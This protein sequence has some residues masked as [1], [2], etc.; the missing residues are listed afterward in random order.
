MGPLRQ[1]IAALL[2]VGGLAAATATAA[3]VRVAIE[4]D[5]APLS[6]LSPEGKPTGFAVDLVHAIA[7]EMRFEVAPVVGPWDKILTAFKQGEADVLASVAYLPERAEFIDFAV[8]HLTFKAAI[9][10]RDDSPPLGGVADIAKVRVAVARE[11][12]AYEYLRSRGLDR[13]PVF[14]NTLQ[15]ALEA[16]DAGR[17][18]AVLGTAV[19]SAH[20]IRTRNFHRVVPA[21]LVL[22]DLAYQLHLGVRSG[23]VR[24]LA[25]LN[26]GL[27][28]IRAN[29]VYDRIYEEWIGPLEPR[30]LRFKDVHPYLLPFAVLVAAVAGAF[31]WQRRL[32]VRLA[33]QTDQIRASEERL[34][35]VL[36]GSSDGFWDWDMVT[37]RIERSERWA[38]MLGYT[39]AEITPTHAGG[40]SHIHADDLPNYRIWE[41][42]LTTGKSDRYEVEYRMR[43]KSGD[44][45]WVL[46]RGKVVSRDANG[47]PLRMAGTHTDITKRKQTEAALVESQRLLHRSHELLEQTQ[48]VARIGGWEIDLRTRHLYWTEGNYQIHETTAADYQPTVAGALEF[49]S[50]ESRARLQ[51]ALEQ[52]GAAGAALDLELDLVTARGRRRRIR[53]SAHV[54]LADNR[55]VRI[56]GSNRDI[57]AEYE[58]AA[59][60]EK[61]RIKMLETQKLESLG[62]L[63]GGIA[64]DFNNLLTGILVNATSSRPERAG[65]DDRL[66]EIASAARRAAD[67]CRQMLA[68]AGR[69]SFLLETLDLGRL[70]QDTARLLDVSISKKTR[71][72]LQLTP[73][74]PSVQ[75]DPSQLRQ[76]IMN[77]LINAAEAIGEQPGE[78]RISTNRGRPAPGP[79]A[80][81]H[82][83]DLPDGDCVVLEVAD[84][85]PGMDQATLARIYDPFFTTKFTGR[86]L[87]LAAVYGIVRSLHGALVVESTP[88]KGTT[89][90]VY[91]P[92]VA[93]PAPV[94]VGPV[95]A[96]PPPPPPSADGALILVADDERIVLSSVDRMLRQR[97][98]RTVLATDGLEAVRLFRAQPEA[99]AAVVLDLTMPGL[100]GAEALHQM[101]S[102]APGIRA[103]LVSGF[104]EQEV[105]E[106]LR[107]QNRVIVLPKPFTRDS[108]HEHLARVFAA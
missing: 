23:N 72:L 106:R 56:Y 93:A 95:V 98:Y 41:E 36:E 49:Y 12:F 9:F 39:L 31:L 81:A 87:G 84:T 43:T 74:L 55:P 35:L 29:G 30:P 80:I 85:G 3:P 90:R 44:W 2:A 101:R 48:A 50:P 103:L 10:R 89:F 53:T 11:S 58:S 65:D 75:A 40:A 66:S 82:V 27:A 54:E 96:P 97:G 26:E 22:D 5:A 77:F 92:V 18:D 91:F 21:G 51:A 73:N 88:Q 105:L 20:L 38:T 25:T 63:A 99:F 64:H 47:R 78:I 94:E 86:G 57:T 62:L 46:D 42:S 14:V 107:D 8:S 28:R 59:E 45:C 68:Y 102:L 1:F 32:L 60:Q 15:E 71:L 16:V 6:S 108:L 76:V 13:S 83:F 24:L 52:A 79:E 19:I 104:S 33:R 69:G 34:A 61:L 70:V 7:R 100:D 37:G 17:A 67:L 4:I